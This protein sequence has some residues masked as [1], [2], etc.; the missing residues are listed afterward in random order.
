VVN[1]GKPAMN[2]RSLLFDT[3]R[4]NLSEVKEHFIN[5]CCFGEDL[6]AW[7][8][9]RLTGQGIDA[10]APGQEDWG[11]YLGARCG[12]QS[13]FLG[14]NGNPKAEGSDEGEWRI[15]IEKTRSLWD[16]VTGRGKILEDDQMVRIV[17]EILHEEPAFQNVRLEE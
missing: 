2:A 14:M 8:R 13:Y 15:I 7:L 16:I 6:A 3:A 17:R 12:R 5:P 4:F 10:S 1:G 9:D 11:W